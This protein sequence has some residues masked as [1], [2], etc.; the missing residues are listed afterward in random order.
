MKRKDAQGNKIWHT[1]PFPQRHANMSLIRYYRDA[2]LKIFHELGLATYVDRDAQWLEPS[3]I[4][5]S[6]KHISAATKGRNFV[7]T[8]AQ[9]F[10]LTLSST[11]LLATVPQMS[12]SYFTYCS[13]KVEEHADANIT[14]YRYGK[15][16]RLRSEGVINQTTSEL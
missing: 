16:N 9:L 6:E 13:S 11:N 3:S 5:K 8:Y 10:L 14:S 4:S 15:N 2:A 7:A 1:P 12:C